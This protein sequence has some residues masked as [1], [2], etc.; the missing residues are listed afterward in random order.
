M[1]RRW[2]LAGTVVGVM[3]TDPSS[4]TGPQRS[5][6]RSRRLG[7]RTI[8]ISLCI[9]LIAAL[10]A[11]LLTSVLY[12]D[13]PSSAGAPRRNR[14][15]LSPRKNID[16]A[17]ALRTRLLTFDGQKTTLAARTGNGRATVVNFFSTTCT[18]CITEM[19]AFERVHR[20]RHDVSFIGIDVQDQVGPGKQL[21]KRTGITYDALRDPPADLLRA[22]GGVGLP[23]TLLIDADRRVVAAHTGA[24]TEG[25]LRKLI[26]SKLG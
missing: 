15:T 14:L 7:G 12:K 20:R 2:D 26:D 9:A 6:S 19:P 24:L 17:K 16:L 1:R 10:G 4:P 5:P 11:G 3:P 22:V 23:T 25:A 8:G 13:E 21:I 18:P